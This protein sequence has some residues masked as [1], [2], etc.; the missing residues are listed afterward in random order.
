VNRADK[1]HKILSD[2]RPHSRQEIFESVGFML[3]NNAA[4]E[5]RARGVDV[6]HHVD[7]GLHIYRLAGSLQQPSS[8]PNVQDERSVHQALRGE[9]GS[10]SETVRTPTSSSSEAV[11]LTL[12]D[13]QA[14]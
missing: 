3:T 13:E 9:D 2:G 6:E 14:A 1:L 7:N 11:S 10:L 5:L 4:S 12:F 8:I